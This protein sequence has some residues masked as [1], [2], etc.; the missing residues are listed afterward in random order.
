VLPADQLA[1]STAVS[2]AVSAITHVAPNPRQPYVGASAFA[3]KAG[4]HG[5]AI[6]VDANLYQHTD[7]RLVGNDMRMLVS[8]MAGRASIQLKGDQL[9]FDLSDRDL[10]ARITDVVKQREMEGYSYESADASFDLLLRHE[11]QA[12]DPA[13]EVLRWRVLTSDDVGPRTATPRR[14]SRCGSAIRWS[15]A[16]GGG[17]RARSTRST[18]RCAP[19]WNRRSRGSRADVRTD[20]LPRPHPGDGSRH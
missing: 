20:G 16:G 4:L 8:D 9:G 17:V 3:H 5:S 11:T 2:H 1:R 14:R 12:L 10:A 6:K 18:T 13:F 19:R 7:P 15:R